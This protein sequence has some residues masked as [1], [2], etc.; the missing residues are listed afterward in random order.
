M[1]VQSTLPLHPIATAPRDGTWM[2]LWY[3]GEFGS[4]WVTTGYWH[5]GH[6]RFFSAK[7]FDHCHTATHWS[8]LPKL[9]EL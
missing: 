6:L 3:V 7:G 1:T 8:P 5:F 4:A 9:E 2:V